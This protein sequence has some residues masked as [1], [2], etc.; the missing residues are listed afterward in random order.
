MI[1]VIENFA[2]NEPSLQDKQ[3]YIGVHGVI[4]FILLKT[5]TTGSNSK[6]TIE[7]SLL[8]FYGPIQ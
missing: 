3:L 6:R 5:P 2:K 1:E 4:S 8:D 7:T